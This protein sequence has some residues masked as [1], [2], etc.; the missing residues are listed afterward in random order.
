MDDD[1]IGDGSGSMMSGWMD[2]RMDD[3]EMYFILASPQDLL[4]IQASADA[5]HTFGDQPWYQSQLDLFLMYAGAVLAQQ[6]DP[7]DQV[8]KVVRTEPGLFTLLT[9][10]LANPRWVYCGYS[11]SCGTVESE[12][13]REGR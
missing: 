5:G 3:D 11:C 1:L 10:P 6:A 7:Q 4:E 12:C 2:G 8:A 13:V 9:W